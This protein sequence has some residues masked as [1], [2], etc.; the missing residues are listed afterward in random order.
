MIR[1][2]SNAIDLV[3]SDQY[4]CVPTNYNLDVS[5]YDQIEQHFF[6]NFFIV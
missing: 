2:L 4:F 3:G 1:S 6:L 5:N